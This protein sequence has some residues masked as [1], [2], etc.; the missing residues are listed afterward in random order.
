[1]IDKVGYTRPVATPG[2]VRK[3]GNVGASGF[4]DALASAQEAAETGETVATAPLNATNTASLLGFQEVDSD[5][6]ERQKAFKRGRLTLEAL[7][8]LRDAL[9]MGSL[10]LSTIERL[11]KLVVAERGQ[12]TDPTLNSILDEIELR[13][14]VEIAKLEVAR[15]M[16]A[17]GSPAT[18][19]A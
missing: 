18:G 9:L 2:K 13:A 3:A 5:Q 11:E 6:F 8:Q 12:T 15:G 16:T 17:P 4:S 7:A 1:M 10:P 19:N 14:A